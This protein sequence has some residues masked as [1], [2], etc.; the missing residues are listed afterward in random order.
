M[1]TSIEVTRKVYDDE[2][3]VC[4]SIGP[5][6]DGLDLIRVCTPSQSDEDWFGKV[7]FTMTHEFARSFAKA[8]LVASDDAEESE[9]ANK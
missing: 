4:L 5:D 8:I 7:S 9:K 6:G 3:G 2:N 1:T